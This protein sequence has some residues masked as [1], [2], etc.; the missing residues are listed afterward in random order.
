MAG[1]IQA[2][3][4]RPLA[5]PHRAP[6]G[7]WAGSSLRSRRSRAP[8]PPLRIP[9]GARPSSTADALAAE[10]T[11]LEL[12]GLVGE[13]AADTAR[14]RELVRHDPTQR[15]FECVLDEP[16]VEAWLICWMPGH[17]TGFHDHDVSSGAATVLA[18]EVREERLGLGGGVVRAAVFGSGDTFDFSK[19]DIHRV[20]HAGTAPAV[21][22]HAYSPRLR[23]LGA[24]AV[25]RDGALQRRPL[26]YGEELRPLTPA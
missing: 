13:L 6:D 14:W 5:S 15:V 7:S 11:R 26:A 21:T 2:C 1:A 4:R 17:D 19:H 24:Y 12:R 22:L 3:P 8:S 10:L 25:T 18:G 16:A 20:T 9:S 23:R